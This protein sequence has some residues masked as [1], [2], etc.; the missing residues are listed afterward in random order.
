MDKIRVI[1]AENDEKQ[2]TELVQCLRSY[3]CFHIAGETA[4]GGEAVRMV[5]EHKPQLLICNMILHTY[6]APAILEE[7]RLRNASMPKTIVISSVAMENYIAKAFAKGADE[8]LLKPVNTALM[9]RRICELLECPDLLQRQ[10]EGEAA[11]TAQAEPEA[12]GEER[13]Y[14][15][16]SALFLRIGLPAHLTGFR[17]AQEAVMM[18]VDDP[19]LLKNRTKV[20]YPAIGER[21]HTTSFCVERAIRHIIN[22]TWDRGIAARYEKEHGQS[23]RLHLPAD[24]PTSGEF[25]ALIAEYVRPRRRSLPVNVQGR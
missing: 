7:L 10:P 18:L 1:I 17:Y 14:Q 6:D 15:A 20:L 2:R 9:L 24:R 25:I 12:T 4:D 8:Y 16:V 19:S 5:L 23:S 11:R 3:P 21:N 22:L 13:L